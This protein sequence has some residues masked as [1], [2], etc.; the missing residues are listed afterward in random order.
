[1]ESAGTA[2]MRFRLRLPGGTSAEV[3]IPGPGRLSVHNALAAAAVGFAA[4]LTEGEIAGGLAIGWQAPHRMNLLRAGGVTIV[5]DTYNASP[6]SVAAALEMLGGLPGRRIA[7]LGEMLELGEAHE[8]GHRRVGEAAA[9]VADAVVVIG[10]GAR[11][12]ADGARATGF[13]RGSIIVVSDRDGALQHLERELS[14]GD[15]VLVKASRGIE[16]DRLVDALVRSLESSP[17]AR[18]RD[19]TS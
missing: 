17:D 16:L 3:S 15:V 1:V 19:E 8:A 9:A 10:D 5:D 12:I 2:G 13:P 14:R 7:V 18:T 6:A 11:G 4:G